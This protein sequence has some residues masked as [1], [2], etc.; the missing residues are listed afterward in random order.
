[1]GVWGA[2][3]FADDDALDVRNDYRH[4]LA[5]AQSDEGATETIARQY[6]ASFEDIGATTSFWLGLAL[7]QWKMGRLDPRVKSAALRIIDEGIDLEKWRNSPQRPN[8]VTALAAARKNLLELP[9]PA[10]PIPKPLPVQL[11]D[12]QFGEVIGFRARNGR[13]VLLHMLGYSRS[14]RHKVKAPRVSV[15]NWTRSE[16]P[17][18]EDVLSLAYINW[19]GIQRG[20]HLYVL[21]APRRRPI[22]PDRFIRLGLFKN[23]TRP[24]AASA[25]FGIRDD[26]GETIDS[27]LE[28]V[29]RPYWEDPGLSPHRPEF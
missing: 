22:S 7:T 3:I 24:E 29:L 23:L 4:F 16:P 8:R 27:M 21:A 9:P 14:S 10:R 26:L 1:M 5:D 28:E 12:W 13:M 20:T 19:R 6:G 15:L 17:T 2:A 25:Y 11:P 18:Q